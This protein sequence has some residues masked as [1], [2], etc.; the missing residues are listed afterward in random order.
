MARTGRR[1]E[2]SLRY[3]RM[4]QTIHW[5]TNTQ[6]A[7]VRLT[8]WHRVT[9]KE[10]HNINME[11]STF[12]E[13]SSTWS[14]RNGSSI[15]LHQDQLPW[16]TLQKREEIHVGKNEIRCDLQLAIKSFAISCRSCGHSSIRLSM[17]G[18]T[19]R[20]SSSVESTKLSWEAAETTRQSRTVKPAYNDN[21]CI[22]TIYNMTYKT[23]CAEVHSRNI[24]ERRRNLA[25]NSLRSNALGKRWG[26][27]QISP[28]KDCGYTFHTKFE[29]HMSSGKPTHKWR[30][31]WKERASEWRNK[32]K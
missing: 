23:M 25:W 31:E 27:W 8:P 32:K 28:N 29:Q 6:V 21:S 20:T 19:S 10:Q 14:T 30:S 11:S 4:K 26:K 12:G 9:C 22:L 13:I 16:Q 15:T 1:I 2:Y 17:Y 3:Y 5:S 7:N 24:K 18:T